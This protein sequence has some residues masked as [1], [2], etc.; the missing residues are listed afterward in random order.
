MT[1]PLRNHRTRGSRA[2]VSKE[3][4]RSDF[5]GELHKILVI[6]GWAG[7]TIDAGLGILRD[8]GGIPADAEAVAIDTGGGVV[9]FAEAFPRGEGLSDD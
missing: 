6:P 2:D 7:A 8:I 9:R 1:Q 5:L 3:K 4:V